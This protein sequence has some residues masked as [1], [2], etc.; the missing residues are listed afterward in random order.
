MKQHGL[1][2]LA[3]IM[4]GQEP[5][6][7]KVL[8]RLDQD[9]LNNGLINFAALA[10]VHYA[11]WVILPELPDKPA[12]LLFETN[13]DGELDAHLDD[14]FLHGA[15]ALDAVYGHCSGYPTGGA[16]SSPAEVKQ[17]LI[18]G[19][20]PSAAYYIG[21]PGRSL[22]DIRN[23]VA[24]YEEAQEFIKDLRQPH[25]Y[26]D[27]SGARRTNPSGFEKL[28]S[29]QVQDSLV[30]HFRSSKAKSHPAPP[31][32][33]R[34][35]R[36][37]FNWILGIGRFPEVLL[38]TGLAYL[39]ERSEARS[40]TRPGNDRTEH[41]I[42]A[43]TYLNLDL[44]LQNHL[45]TFTTVK[46]SRARRFILKRVLSIVD[47]FARKIFIF[48][49]LGELST[50]HF[51]KWIVVDGDGPGA[52][53]ISSDQ[54]LLF[55]SNYDGSWAS[56]LGDFSELAAFGL[57]PIWSNTLGFLP[58]TALFFG[59]ASDIDRFEEGDRKHFYPAQVF[60]SAYNRYPVQNLVSYLDF[61]DDLA[62]K[63]AAAEKQE[64][65]KW[66]ALEKLQR[67]DH[68]TVERR[69]LQGLVAH[70]YLHLHHARYLFLEI[71]DPE[72]AIQWLAGIVDRVSTAKLREPSD[73]VPRTHLNIAF[74]KAGLEAL[75][76]PDKTLKEFPHEFLAGMNRVE[77]AAILGD[78]GASASDKWQFG[79]RDS[80]GRDPLHMMILLFATSVAEVGRLQHE[81]LNAESVFRQITRID[82]DSTD[83]N[84]PFG[85][86]DGISQPEV[87][88]LS[89]TAPD[90]IAEI[91]R[92]GEFVLGYENEHGEV[93]RSPGVAAELDREDVLLPHPDSPGTLKA[94]GLNG[95]FLVARKL[96]QEV[97]AFWRYVEKESL[98]PDGTP[99]PERREQLAAKLMGRWRSGAPLLLT[100]DRDVPIYART[101]FSNDFRYSQA[102]PDGLLCP[103]GSH[104]RRA[105]PRDDVKLGKPPVIHTQS[106]SAKS[107]ML[108]KRH[109]II[110]RGRKY[111]EQAEDPTANDQKHM[112]EGILFIAINADI[113][114]QFE[115]VQQTWLNS[116]IFQ[117]LDNDKDPIVGDNDGS[118]RFTIQD[119]PA[120]RRLEGLQRF[121]TVKGGG[122]FFLPSIR[123]L[124]FLA[125]QKLND[126]GGLGNH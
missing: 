97:G 19:Q 63:I 7:R 47:F 26:V 125:N 68:R 54:R 56:Y 32:P 51:A 22:R 53:G 115:F 90:R 36:L 108:S 91:V 25:Y 74:T 14:L 60:Y 58:T 1:T 44:G 78:T 122:Y 117:G 42:D 49:K 121:V 87:M 72:R 18:Q 41:K 69:D 48:G 96:A 66:R 84:E 4:P 100:P 43:E 2:T 124:R 52:E 103:V 126:S 112:A 38:L 61:S 55:V 5:A 21:L 113:A 11:S 16:A 95:S 76:L 85:F 33:R 31:A 86:R 50:I 64:R 67:Q 79:S 92:P 119:K 13:Y 15:S 118:T 12:R 94:F 81:V 89:R 70:G 88:S 120:N 83:R 27:P 114:R 65:R 82:A 9:Q 73:P 105:N 93:T 20:V 116:P 106:I 17:F 109:R 62:R 30:R 77:A 35:L 80:K 102:D 34:L 8:A 101:P 6:L 40:Q 45:C 71:L 59:G 104:I 111:R 110:R 10:T 24:V 107:L 46:R 99:D 3:D 23:A 29:A 39:C 98:K 37:L 57:N 75:G 28:T 123:A